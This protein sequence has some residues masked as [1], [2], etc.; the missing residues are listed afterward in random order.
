MILIK[1]GSPKT[2]TTTLD[3]EHRW[4]PQSISRKMVKGKIC[5]V[6]PAIA[7][8][9]FSTVALKPKLCT[10]LFQVVL[11]IDNRAFPAPSQQLP[12][13]IQARFQQV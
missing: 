9:L 6:G 12:I 2:P 4:H 3:P 10:G 7:T 11:K 1:W 8:H 5:S 13:F